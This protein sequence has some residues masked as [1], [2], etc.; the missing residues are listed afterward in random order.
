M[1]TAEIGQLDSFLTLTYT[2][3]A[4]DVQPQ[5]FTAYQTKA[6]DRQQVKDAD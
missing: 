5:A 6:V 3:L 1:K 4:A 2:H